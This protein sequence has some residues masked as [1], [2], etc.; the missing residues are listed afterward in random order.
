MLIETKLEAECIGDESVLI[1]MLD[2]YVSI[3]GQDPYIGQVVGY[4]RRYKE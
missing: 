1:E 2:R 3:N 4:C